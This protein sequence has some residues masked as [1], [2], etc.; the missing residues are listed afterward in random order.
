MERGKLLDMIR[1][2][3]GYSSSRLM[4]KRV[5]RSG[6]AGRAFDP[7]PLEQINE[8]YEALERGGV[9]RSVMRF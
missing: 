6:K 9:A 4:E 5:E 3:N 8:A 7:N 1:E 2:A